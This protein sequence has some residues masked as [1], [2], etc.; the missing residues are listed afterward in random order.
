MAGTTPLVLF[1][2]VLW[3]CA[4]AG[5]SVASEASGLDTGIGRRDGPTVQAITGTPGADG[6]GDS[7]YAQLGNGGYDVSHYDI[8][9]DVNPTTGDIVAVTTIDAKATQDLSAFNLDLSGLTVS[10]V[11]VDGEAA[12]FSRNGTELTV[13]PATPLANESEF[14]VVVSYSGNPGYLH[15]PHPF[16]CCTKT[17]GWFHYRQDSFPRGVLYARNRIVGAMT[18]FPC[19]NH[20]TDKATFRFEIT[21][22][23]TMTAVATGVRESEVTADGF[24]TSVWKMD[25]PM[26][27]FATGVF[28]GDFRRRDVE[29]EEMPSIRHYVHR[30]HVAG[31]LDAVTGAISLFEGYLGDF[32]FDV[33][34]VIVMPFT[35][36][37]SA[38]QSLSLHSTDTVDAKKISKRVAEQWF[39][40]SSTLSDWGD[41]WLHEGFADYLQNVYLAH[42]TWRTLDYYMVDYRN[43]LLRSSGP[44]LNNLTKRQLYSSFV[45]R[46]G[47]LALHALRREVG[48]TVFFQILTAAHER[49]AGANTSTE[50]FLEIVQEL[51]DADALAVVKSWIHSTEVPKFNEAPEFPDTE[52]GQRSVAEGTA[53]GQNVGAVFVATDPE[54]DDLTLS[55]S[56]S[57]AG[58]F[59]FDASTG[60]LTTKSPLDRETKSSYTFTVRVSDRKDDNDQGDT[61]IDDTVTVTVEVTDVNEP[62]EFPGSETGMRSVYKAIAAGRNVGSPV[63]AIDPENDQLTYSLTGTGTADFDFDTSTGQL[64]T[65][66]P[67]DSEDT[68]EYSFTVQVSDQK[69]DND[70][71]DSTIDDTIGLTVRVT[72]VN[73]PPEITGDSSLDFEEGGTGAVGTFSATDP[74]SESF[75]WTLS[76]TDQGDFTITGGELGFSTS[77]DYE[78]P[79]DSSRNN[80]YLVTVRASDGT[81]TAS[82][83]VTVNVTDVNEPPEFPGSETGMRSVDEGTLAGRNIGS[84]VRATDPENDQ[85]TYSLTGTGSA[86]FDI[87][88]TTGQLKTKNPLDHEEAT[89]HS[90]T[91]QVS[92]RKDDNDETDDTIDDTIGLTVRV[93]DVNEPPEITGDSGLDYEEGGT[94]AVG[95]FSATDPENEN[96]TW[97]LSGTDRSDFTITGGELGFS[98]SPDYEM[99]A[100][101]NRNNQYLVTVRASDGVQTATLGVTVNVTNKDEEPSLVLSSQQPQEGTRVTA[102]L[103]DPDGGITNRTWDWRRSPTGTTG[104]WTEITGE[105]TN[106]YTP[107]ADDLS[108]YLRAS[109]AYDDG[110]GSGKDAEA[111]STHP[112]RAAP[113]VN[114]PPDFPSTETGVRSVEENLI[115]LVDIGEPVTATDP[116]TD[117]L[118]YT[119]SGTH[120]ALFT[121][122]SQTGQLRTSAPF[123]YE[124]R[125][126]YTLRVTASD[127]N[128]TSDSV[129]LTVIVINVDEQ[130]AVT[131][132][133]RVPK[134]GV[135]LRAVLTDP[136]G[137]IQDVAWKW[138]IS[139]YGNGPWTEITGAGGNTYRPTADDVGDYLQVSASYTDR[140]GPHKT[141]DP[142]RSNRVEPAGTIGGGEP[143]SI[144]GAGAPSGGGGG[145]GGG[146]G[147]ASLDERSGGEGVASRAAELFNDVAAGVW[148]ESAVSWMILHGITVGCSPTMFCPDA[149]LTRQQFVTFLWRA[150]GRPPAPYL[151]SEA[152]T[153]VRQ[154]AYSD[155]AIG[156]AVAN[157]I[158]R[159]CTTGSFGDETWRFCPTQQVTRGEMAT[160]LYRHTEATY[161]G[162]P[163]H[164]TDIE[165]DAFYT[166]SITWLTDFVVVPGCDTRLFCPNR[167][168]TR[169]EAA[170]FINGVAIRPHIWGPDNTSFIP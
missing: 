36:P 153:D 22:P 59:A 41:I 11:T 165:P 122:D 117:P 107:T 74:D 141:A 151:G 102:T 148:Y 140:E 39:G 147:A 67:L 130:G 29:D 166:T 109:V 6:V 98:T 66:N 12:T 152:F 160:L 26:A 128:L 8:D 158:T 45:P 134:E 55:V 104:S 89:E 78:M 119:I 79:A 1:F 142:V 124:G 86:D 170:L 138:E 18:W 64:K 108:Q 127:P 162:A 51:G 13:T 33:Y 144:G 52:T 93:G 145:G 161:Q 61:A 15:E 5:S 72:D 126:S 169:A 123:N 4:V 75:T 77:P 19:N 150:A 118:T 100:D 99:P 132:P 95:F 101:S 73:Q 44:A 156:W 10:S 62:P 139:S 31:G 63:T 2:A 34:G 47:S 23:D 87:H 17:A 90:L 137:G 37:S 53:A 70:E 121:I 92:D 20:P 71:S 149:N 105:D 103:S 60:Q 154:G 91:V 129:T 21:V 80:Q 32:P 168:A 28:V 125:R 97:S 133:T 57:D 115:G 84:P 68:T 30:G 83:S 76:G 43:H 110:H 85:L 56:G 120:A 49:T 113:V 38:L 146:G 157:D 116:D 96:I 9:L 65:K 94:G 58:H 50:E 143:Q 7:M 46:R 88:A 114:G 24:T 16:D 81:S 136:D 27:T 163:P 14:R 42:T 135:S 3:L 159:G 40:V 35:Y 131:L 25:D 69:N 54:E 111:V 112:V 48:D 167:A 82:L 164:Y 106:R 155:Q